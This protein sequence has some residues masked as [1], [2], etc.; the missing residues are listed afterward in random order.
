M[1][2]LDQVRSDRLI[3][4][5]ILIRHDSAGCLAARQGLSSSATY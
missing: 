1:P 3:P 5:P 4:R 2:A